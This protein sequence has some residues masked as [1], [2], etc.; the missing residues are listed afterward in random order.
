MEEPKEESLPSQSAYTPPDST[1]EEGLA[2]SSS[3][4]WIWQVTRASL[5]RQTFTELKDFCRRHGIAFMS[6]SPLCGPCQLASP[7]DSLITGDLTTGIGRRYNKTGA[8]VALRFIVQ[9]ALAENGTMAGVI[10]K[11]NNPVHVA[12]NR[13]IF[14]WT[15]SDDDMQTLHAAQ[16]PAAEAGDCDVP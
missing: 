5:Q 7:G 10:P 6:F 14:G 15:L 1:Y 12:Q 9:Q 3:P 4:A 11:S 2:S 13:D 8:Q 16:Q